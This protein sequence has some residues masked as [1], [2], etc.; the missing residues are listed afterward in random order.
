[1]ITRH[2]WDGLVLTF[3]VSA[4]A[5]YTVAILSSLHRRGFGILRKCSTSVLIAPVAAAVLSLL[6]VIDSKFYMFKIVSNIKWLKVRTNRTDESMF[7]VVLATTWHRNGAPSWCAI[8]F[9]PSQTSR[10]CTSKSPSWV[11]VEEKL[12]SLNLAQRYGL[13]ARMN[14]GF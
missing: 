9:F 3:V 14:F 11:G 5:L 7:C 10:I 2:L 1:M 6:V 12:H 4:W 8:S 13:F